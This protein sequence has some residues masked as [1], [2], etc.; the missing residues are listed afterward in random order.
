MKEIMEE[1]STTFFACV[2]DWPE[3][4]RQDI[5]KL[6]AY[7]R[8]VDEMVEG[9]DSDKPF[10]EWRIVIEQFHEVSDKYQFEGEWL[11]DFHHAMLTD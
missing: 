6:Y 8:V 5:Y 7:L 3:E 10:K 2:A 1:Y 11:A 4:I 9:V